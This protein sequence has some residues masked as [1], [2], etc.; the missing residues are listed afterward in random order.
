MIWFLRIIAAITALACFASGLLFSWAWTYGYFFEWSGLKEQWAL[1]VCRACATYLGPWPGVVFFA[2]AL[3]LTFFA[4]TM[5]RATG[6]TR[7][8]K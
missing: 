3:L 8:E 7:E 2:A 1:P 6:V 4:G 5:L